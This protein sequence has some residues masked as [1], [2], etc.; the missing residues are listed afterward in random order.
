M[1]NLEN[2]NTMKYMYKRLKVGLSPWS[3][4]RGLNEA[5]FHKEHCNTP[6]VVQ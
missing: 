5:A 6:P 2:K 3:A 1:Q 4:V